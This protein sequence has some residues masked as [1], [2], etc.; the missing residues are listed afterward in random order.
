MNDPRFAQSQDLEGPSTGSCLCRDG[1]QPI[2]TRGMVRLPSG[3]SNC[4][5]LGWFQVCGMKGLAHGFMI[6]IDC[7]FRQDSQ[8]SPGLLVVLG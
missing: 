1:H 6:Q 7:L 2:V 3:L 4:F 8:G 5:H